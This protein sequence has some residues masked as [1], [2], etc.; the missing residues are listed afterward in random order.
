MPTKANYPS[1]NAGHP[2]RDR[3]TDFWRNSVL[4]GPQTA[5]LPTVHNEDEWY[6]DSDALPSNEDMVPPIGND[7]S[8]A[9]EYHRTQRRR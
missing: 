6:T 3:T 2:K 8:G 9:L 1:Q 7:K 4:V 5:G